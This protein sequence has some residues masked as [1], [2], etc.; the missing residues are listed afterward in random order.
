MG[1]R[2]FTPEFKRSAVAL[3]IEQKYARQEAAKNLG[4]GV[5]TLDNWLG[6]HRKRNGS[7]NVAEELDL[8]KRVAQLE[9]EN[10]RLTMERDILKKA[11]AYFA[12]E[13]L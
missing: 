3:V 12:R 2:T 10:R 5:A 4:I 11:T 7:V 1:R 9:R 13:Q 6:E 8:K